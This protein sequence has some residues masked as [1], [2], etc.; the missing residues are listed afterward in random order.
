M[1]RSYTV[2]MDIGNPPRPYTL[3]MDTGSYVTWIQCD[4]PCIN[5]HQAPHRPYKPQRID[6]A[7][8]KDHMCDFVDHPANY[9]CR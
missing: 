2:N 9:P 8:C 4:A 3:D 7:L 5:C 1:Y 6:A